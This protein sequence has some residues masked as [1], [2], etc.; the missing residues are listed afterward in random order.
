MT[1]SHAEHNGTRYVPFADGPTDIIPEPWA[2]DIIRLLYA[3]HRGIFAAL[4]VKRLG[5]D[6]LPRRRTDA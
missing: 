3:D 1:E 2:E 6:K 5:I 4:M